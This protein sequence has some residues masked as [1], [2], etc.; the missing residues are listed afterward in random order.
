MEETKKDCRAKK[1]LCDLM[2]DKAAFEAVKEAAKNARFICKACG[3][4]AGKA[5]SLC[6]PLSLDA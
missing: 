6:D 4:T 2:A 5:E 1:H 3:R